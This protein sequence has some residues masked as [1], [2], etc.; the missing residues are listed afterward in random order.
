[1][2]VGQPGVNGVLVQLHVGTDIKYKNEVAQTLSLTMGEKNVR[3]N[4]RNGWIANNKNTVQV[5]FIKI[6]HKI[7]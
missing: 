3:E 5:R 2:V 4:W 6:T 7:N 1:M